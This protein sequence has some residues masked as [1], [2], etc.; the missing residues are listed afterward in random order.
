MASSYSAMSAPALTR[1]AAPQSM[2]AATDATGGSPLPPDERSVFTK[3][4]I[5]ASLK[6]H[7]L[8]RQRL[9]TSKDFKSGD[10]AAASDTHALY[11]GP[12]MNERRPRNSTD[13][14]YVLSHPSAM[15]PLPNARLVASGING[16]HVGIQGN[17]AVVTATREGDTPDVLG[18][19]GHPDRRLILPLPEPI[20]GVGIPRAARDEWEAEWHAFAASSQAADGLQ[21]QLKVA[22]PKDHEMEAIWDGVEESLGDIFSPAAP[23]DVTGGGGAS[24]TTTS[25]GAIEER[26]YAAIL[27][28]RLLP[29]PAGA[30]PRCAGA[31]GEPIDSTTT[32]ET[33]TH[34]L[35]TC[36]V[37]RLL[38][39]RVA[40]MLFHLWSQP[41]A[42]ASASNMQLRPVAAEAAAAAPAAEDDADRVS[43]LDVLLGFPALRRRL[44]LFAAAAASSPSPSASSSTAAPS[45]TS[46]TSSSASAAASTSTIRPYRA[47]PAP[48]AGQPRPTPPPPAQDP[49]LRLLDLAHSVALASLL[50]CRAYPRAPDT[51]AWSLFRARFERRLALLDPGTAAAEAAAAS[52]AS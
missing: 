6:R 30:C 17:T 14:D 21:Q 52:D 34:F 43:P 39:R 36:P 12:N 11:S 22:F 38:W 1:L 35:F 4:Q 5:E 16:G 9:G 7:Y 42:V 24:A 51:V 45:S 19:I 48:P 50:A 8:N 2:P 41:T 33:Y 29:E 47:D 32:I 40:I 27:Q 26:L 18:T 28:R 49:R 31:A 15:P 46:S 25:Q 20:R 23:A 37:A 44:L 3:E 13:S 10:A